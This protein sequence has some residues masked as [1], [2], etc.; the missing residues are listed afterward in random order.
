MVLATGA[1]GLLLTAGTPDATVVGEPARGLRALLPRGVAVPGTALGLGNL[2]YAAMVGFLVVHL[3]DRGGHGAVA[4][5]AFSVAVLLGRLG[6]R[7]ARRPASG[8]CGRCRTAWCAMAA[9]LLVIAA[10]GSTVVAASAA[11]VVGLGYCLPFP[12]LATLVAGPRP[13][14][15]ARGGHRRADRVL[16][17]LR[18]RRL[19]RRRAGRRP[20]GHLDGLRA[21]GR[22]RAR[23]SRVNVALGR[24]DRRQHSAVEVGA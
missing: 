15:A 3:D 18:G 23:R 10:T 24:S 5:T 13:G 19:G 8:F 17:R 1:V 21:G 9:G 4:L 22:R 6:R 20:G 14:R 12:A 2:G 11:A 16:R 7:P